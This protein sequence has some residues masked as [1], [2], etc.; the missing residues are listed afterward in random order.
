MAEL[1]DAVHSQI[2]SRC[3]RGDALVEAK[4]YAAAI[5]EYQAAWDLVPEPKSEWEAGS[6]ILIAMGDAFYGRCDYQMAEDCLRKS[7]VD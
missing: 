3:G 5:A 6:W 7:V 4:D 2:A 1:P